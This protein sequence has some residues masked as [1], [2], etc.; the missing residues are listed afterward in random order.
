MQTDHAPQI[1]VP[2]AVLQ[3]AVREVPVVLGLGILALREQ[4]LVALVD[5]AGPLSN[6][7]VSAPLKPRNPIKAAPGAK[8]LE[9][10][11][12]KLLPKVEEIVHRKSATVSC[13]LLCTSAAEITATFTVLTK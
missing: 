12:L 7:S 13:P 8:L 9:N 3:N 11:S 10:D 1:L 5:A 2:D 6:T 4:Q